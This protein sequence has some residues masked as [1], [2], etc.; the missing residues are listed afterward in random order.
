MAS[1]EYYSTPSQT[2]VELEITIDQDRYLDFSMCNSAVLLRHSNVYREEGK[3]LKFCVYFTC[4]HETEQFE[5][6]G[7]VERAANNETV[8]SVESNLGEWQHL[9]DLH[10]AA[11][12]T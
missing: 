6:V 10:V 5:F 4:G 11:E 1:T 12:R 8:L 9:L 3:N 2:P 7:K